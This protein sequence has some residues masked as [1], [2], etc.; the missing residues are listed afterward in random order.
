MKQYI[1][2]EKLKAEIKTIQQS[3]ENRDVRLNPVKKIRTESMIEL[4]KCVI[5]IINSFQQEQP[6]FSLIL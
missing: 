3:L 5:D 2:S 4:C 6:L 1:D